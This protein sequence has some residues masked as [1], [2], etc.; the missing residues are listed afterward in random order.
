MKFKSL[1]LLWLLLI[2]LFACN[3][4]SEVK[5]TE[6]K[7]DLVLD[8]VITNENLLLKSTKSV[9][10]NEFNGTCIF[11]L[12]D[13]ES[14]KNC[15][16]ILKISSEKGCILSFSGIDDFNDLKNLVLQWGYK[17]EN[18]NEFTMQFPVNLMLAESISINGKTEI[19]MDEIIPPLLKN[20]NICPKNNY[21]IEIHG[22]SESPVT[23]QIKIPIVVVSGKLTSQFTLF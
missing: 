17:D 9:V 21:K 15:S 6:T 12:S 11:C 23:A 22:A 18:A 20:M 1:F 16:D 19:N 14:L 4:K 13:S 7:A 8:M 3:E 5:I 10:N 2:P